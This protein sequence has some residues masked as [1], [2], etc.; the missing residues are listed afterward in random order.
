MA[1]PEIQYT[2]LN[3]WSSFQTALPLIAAAVLWLVVGFFV[4]KIIGRLVRE[5][6]VRIKLDRYMIEKE[7]I[8][9]KLSDIFSKIFKWIIYLVFIQIAAES[10]GVAV[11]TTFIGSAITFI[12]GAIEA[13]ILI[14]VGYSLASYIKDKIIKS[15][16]IYGDLVGKIIFFLIL[17]VSIAL[18]LPFVGIDATLINWILLV[19]IAAVGFGLALAIALGT[20]DVVAELA[21]DYMKH[22]KRKK[23]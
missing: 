22:F 19:I 7:K 20:K 16:T 10:L 21:K 17:Y 2:L 18:A 3:L 1:L 6:L 15:R 5:F 8:T 12:F 23:R 9:V 14:I 4:G 11:L 13:A